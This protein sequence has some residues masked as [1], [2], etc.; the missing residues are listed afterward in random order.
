MIERWDL[1]QLDRNHSEASAFTAHLKYVLERD[2][3]KVRVH[4]RLIEPIRDFAL[5]TAIRP[6]QMTE[7]FE[8]I[9]E[10]KIPIMVHGTWSLR[11]DVILATEESA[12]LATRA[13]I[14]DRAVK[15]GS[16]TAKKCIL[17]YANCGSPKGRH[18]HRAVFANWINLT[19]GAD[20][21]L[22]ANHV[23]D[24]AKRIHFYGVLKHRFLREETMGPLDDLYHGEFPFINGASIAAKG[25]FFV[26][27]PHFGEERPEGYLTYPALW[28]W[29]ARRPLICRKTIQGT[30]LPRAACCI[31]RSKIDLSTIIDNGVMAI[32]DLE[33]MINF[34]KAIADEHGEADYVL[35]AYRDSCAR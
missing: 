31:A 34:G 24:E 23:L 3:A 25:E 33:H 8:T 22:G 7:L 14:I 26:H 1:F 20:W 12:L 11:R 30:E 29:D 9:Q 32:E 15:M 35:P 5:I 2:G 21:A 13:D 4:H 10:L 17:P 6:V 19:Q 28:A 18:E 16:K 27:T